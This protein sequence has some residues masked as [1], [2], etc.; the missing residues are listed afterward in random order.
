MSL[1]KVRKIWIRAL[2][3]TLMLFRTITAAAN[4]QTTNKKQTKSQ[5]ENPYWHEDIVDPDYSESHP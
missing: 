4:K 2:Q 3:L 1:Q 5:K